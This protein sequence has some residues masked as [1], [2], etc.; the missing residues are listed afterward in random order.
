MDKARLCRITVSGF[1]VLAVPHFFH[2]GQSRTSLATPL[3]MFMATALPLDESMSACGFTP[4]TQISAVVRRRT[5][6]SLAG[7]LYSASVTN[8]PLAKS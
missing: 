1:T 6:A 7:N 8:W 5:D 2:D 4:T 3:L